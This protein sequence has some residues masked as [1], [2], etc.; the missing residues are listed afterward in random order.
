MKNVWIIICF[1]AFNYLCKKWIKIWL[2][3][4]F[5]AL[6]NYIIFGS[7][8]NSEVCQLLKVAV[9]YCSVCMSHRIWHRTYMSHV[10]HIRSDT[11]HFPTNMEHV[12]YSVG[13]SF[14]LCSL[15][16]ICHLNCAWKWQ[17]AYLLFKRSRLCTI[18]LIK[19]W[20]HK[21]IHNLSSTN[22]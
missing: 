11:A 15:K 13:F 18:P 21:N 5:N 17:H 8:G 6:K 22:Y 4:H 20:G 3:I 7:R 9:R 14:F 12:P 19:V 2:I 10:W 16:R 1:H